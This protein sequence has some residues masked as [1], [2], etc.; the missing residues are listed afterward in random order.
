MDSLYVLQ[1]FMR[2]W[3]PDGW[4]IYRYRPL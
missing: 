4:W 1:T 2:F 3:E